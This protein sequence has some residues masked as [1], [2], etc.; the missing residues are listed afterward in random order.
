MRASRPVFFSLL[1]LLICPI[2]FCQNG[3]PFA[4]VPAYSLEPVTGNAQPLTTLDQRAAA[5]QLIDRARQ[6][7]N[8]YAP[9]A[10]TFTLAVSFNSSGQLQYEGSGFMRETW[11]GRGLRWSSEFDGI[12]S[13]VRML[14]GVAWASGGPVPMRVQM[15]RDAILWPL[16]NAGFTRG[17][18]RFADVNYNGT[19]LTCILTSGAL[20]DV[21]SPRQWVEKEY[22]IDPQTGL[23]HVW[24]E[25]PGIYTIYDYSNALQFHGHTIAQQITVVEN[26]T[27][28][29]QIHV[30]SLIDAGQVDIRQFM[31]TSEMRAHGHS[32]PLRGPLRYP[33]DVPAAAGVMPKII[34]PVMVHATISRD[35]QVLEEEALQDASQD[36]VRK[37]LALVKSSK[38]AAS[39][40]QREVFVNVEFYLAQQQG[41]ADS[42]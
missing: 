12:S 25:A 21:P 38:Y 4:S 19:A 2:A 28:I 8:F 30:D 10:P 22:C 11:T 34:Q 14:N 41:I 1:F 40:S 9:N 5:L 13:Q 16:A 20:P 15:V 3:I 35:G 7:Y 32:F 23:L 27:P 42:Q 18:F 31:P 33:L 17:M 37:A 26:D 24:S 29:L 39:E 6:N 36:L